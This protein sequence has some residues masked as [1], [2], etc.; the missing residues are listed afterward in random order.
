MLQNKNKK[1]KKLGFDFKGGFSKAANQPK[2]GSR[3]KLSRV[4]DEMEH[5]SAEH[6]A[7]VRARL[8]VLEKIAF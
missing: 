3:L 1:S 7:F 4:F 6:E 5:A 2:G 8:R